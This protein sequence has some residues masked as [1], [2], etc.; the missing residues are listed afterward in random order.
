MNVKIFENRRN[1]LTHYYHILKVVGMGNCIRF[2]LYSSVLFLN[3]QLVLPD[4]KDTILRILSSH[5]QQKHSTFKTILSII[6]ATNR[7]ILTKN[8]I[9]KEKRSPQSGADSSPVIYR[10]INKDNL[11]ILFVLGGGL[12]D[13]IVAANYIFKFVSEFGHDFI[14][15]D[16]LTQSVS[17]DVAS[18]IFKECYIIDGLYSRDDNSN[19]QDYIHNHDVVLDIRRYPEIRVMNTSKI[20]KYEPRLIEY[21]HLC[22][23]YTDSNQRMIKNKL[24]DGQS[25]CIEIIKGKKRISQP[26]INNYFRISEKYEYKIPLLYD[27]NQLL[28]KY[29]LYSKPFISIHRGTDSRF[30]N[31]VKL[32]PISYYNRLIRYI[33]E[34]YPELIIVQLGINSVR[35]PAMDNIDINLVGMTNLEDVKHILINSKLHIDNEGGFVH[36][37]HALTSNP[38]V[39]LFGPTSD[40]FFGYSDNINIRGPGCKTFCEFCI[41]DWQEHCVRKCAHPPC[42][43]SITPEY[44]FEMV[45]KTLERLENE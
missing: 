31:S 41:E 11:N 25:A 15:Y 14:H 3:G 20:A 37:R 27:T 28:I 23:A 5:T 2:N 26:D 21:L 34:K 44:V 16:V 32:W 4:Y 12:G 18:T 43:L 13:L 38:S 30:D 36:L 22:K 7:Y 1:A 40:L 19:F 35:C 39:V 45:E 24:F 10:N 6:N 42:M 33:K 8:A 29:Q 9:Y 17:P